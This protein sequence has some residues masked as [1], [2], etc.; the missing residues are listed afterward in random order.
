MTD[1]GGAL[2]AF[3][4]HRPL[5]FTIAYEITGS[6]ADAEDAVQESYLRWAA[7]DISK[8]RSPRAYLAQTATRVALNLLRARERRREHYVGPWLPEPVV[9]A[10]DVADDVVLAESVSMAMLVVL[11]SLSPEE[12]AVFLLREVFGFDYDEIAEAVGKSPA[13]TRQVSHRARSAVA[14]RRPRFR[15]DEQ[16][17]EAVLTRFWAA[18]S[19]GDVQSLMTVLAPDVVLLSDGGGKKSA[20]RRPVTGAE[21]V[22]RLILGLVRKTVGDAGFETAVVNGK[23]GTIVSLDGELDSVITY[24]LHDDWID[25]V[26]LIRNPDKLTTAGQQHLLGR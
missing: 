9:T 17:S 22:A 2:A 3:T 4:E 18:V 26:Y 5:L 1:H 23:Q 11:E 25:A 16:R 6:V 24:D 7:I 12:R 8:V 15:T 14:A 20:A 13:A 21:P 10:P 19:T